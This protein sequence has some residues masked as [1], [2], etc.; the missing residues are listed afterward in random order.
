MSFSI[1]RIVG[2]FSVRSRIALLAAIPVVGFLA[3]GATFVSGEGAIEQA[4][5]SVKS[6]GVLADASNDFKGALGAMRIH[7]RD[8]G[9]RPSQ[10][11]IKSFQDAHA[12]AL[13]NL[14]AID[15]A[16]AP[17]ERQSLIPL[18]SRLGEVI[19]NFGELSRNQDQLGF[20]ESDGTRRRMSQSAVAVERVINDDMS[21]MR[22]ADAQKLLVMLLTMRRYESEYRLNGALL[23]QT[24]FFD[25]FKNFKTTLDGDRRRRRHEAA[26]G[27]AGGDLCRHLRRLGR[28]RRQG[29]PADRADRPR[30]PRH[31]AGRRRHHRLRPQERG[32]SVARADGVAVPHQDHHHLGR[33]PGGPDRARPQLAD[34]PQ[35]HP[36][37]QRPG[38]RDEAARRR[39]H[40]GADSRHPRVRRDRRDGAHRDRVPRQHA[41]TRTAHRRAD[42]SPPLAR[43]QRSER[44]AAT[45]AAFRSSV[46]QALGK[47]RGAARPARNV[48]G[49]AQRRRRRR[50]RRGAHRREPRQ[51]RLAERHRGGKLGR[52][53]G[54]LD[55]R[56]R[57]PGRQVDRGRRPRRLGGAPHRARP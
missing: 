38:R 53:A 51:R 54:R 48:V 10:E 14:D 16:V 4:F 42:A 30:H 12:L 24:A 9:A 17:G 47:L 21:W 49:Q 50:A 19:A 7:A 44:I 39:R 20:T 2:R 35:H 29:R 43:E 55:R 22:E 28:K 52:G 1:N 3:N 5:Q 37:A 13:Q 18:R 26:T 56:D 36:P 15:R 27:F 34:R 45:I 23:L 31:D 57:G 25:E 33:L 11:L 8:F 6:A 40:L 46:E 32:R 41:R